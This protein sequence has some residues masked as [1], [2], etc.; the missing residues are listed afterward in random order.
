MDLDQTSM[1]LDGSRSRWIS[2]DLGLDLD[3]T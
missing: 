1:D 3:L 2:M